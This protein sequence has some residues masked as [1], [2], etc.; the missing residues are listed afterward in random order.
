METLYREADVIT[1]HVPLLKETYHMINADTLSKMKK[2][3]ILINCARG[4][5]TDIK[6]LISGI[7][8]EH[9]GALGL[10]CMEYEEDIVHR[11]LRTDI[12]S[13]RDMAYLRQF[14]NVVHTQHMAFYTDS[15][16]KSMVYCGVC[17]LLEM[18]EGKTCAAQLC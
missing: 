7:E 18:K 1:L 5:L 3:I 11:D 2:G 9:I 8:S 15:A 14:K 16:V 12:L 4:A 13:N 17:G 10:D 6:A